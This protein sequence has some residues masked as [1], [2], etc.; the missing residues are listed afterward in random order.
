MREL[1][2]K[3]KKRNRYPDDIYLYETFK[4][5]LQR[6]KIITAYNRTYKY[7]KENPNTKIKDQEIDNLMSTVVETLILEAMPF[8]MISILYS[9]FLSDNALRKYVNKFK[10]KRKP[11]YIKLEDNESV[12]I[13]L[14]ANLIIKQDL[15]K[16]AKDQNKYRK[17]DQNRFPYPPIK[18]TGGYG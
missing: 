13:P 12:L 15:K 10:M 18:I 2:L 9:K 16:K 17:K 7:L 8:T 1:A 5:L 6:C 11:Q 14:E 4:E 3:K